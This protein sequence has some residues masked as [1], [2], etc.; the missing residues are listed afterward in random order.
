MWIY[1]PKMKRKKSWRSFSPV[2]STVCDRCHATQYDHRP[3]VMC[4]ACCYSHRYLASPIAI[5]NKPAKPSI[6]L[7]FFCV[8]FVCLQGGNNAGHTVVV[9]SVEYDFH[10]LPSGIINPTATAFI[11]VCRK[12]NDST[13]H[14]VLPWFRLW[15]LIQLNCKLIGTVIS[16]SAFIFHDWG[17]DRCQTCALHRTV[18][19][20][21]ICSDFIS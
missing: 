15:K 7:V 18:P 20:P 21:F 12:R 3:F 14:S 8:L 1:V 2:C 6:N 4:D 16:T 19:H 13:L 17:C 9:D 5:L 11:G 10:L